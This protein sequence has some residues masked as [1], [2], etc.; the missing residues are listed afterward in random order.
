MSDEMDEIWELFADDGSQSLDAMEAA[1]DALT[2]DGTDD[3]VPHISALFRAVHTFK[4]NSRVVGLSVVEGRA[5]LAEDLIGLVRDSGVPLTPEIIDLLFLTGDTLRIMLDDVAATRADVDPEPSEDLLR[6]LKEMIAKCDPEAEPAPQADPPESEEQA[7]DTGAEA[8]MP[9][10]DAAETPVATAPAIGGM[11]MSALFDEM[12]D[13]DEGGAASGGD[14]EEDD[15]WQ[16]DEDL[17]P[18]ALAAKKAAAEADMEEAESERP[19][20]HGAAA[21]TPVESSVKIDDGPPLETLA[22]DPTYRKI[23]AEMTEDMVEKLNAILRS[24]DA[25]EDRRKDAEKQ[26][27]GLLHAA[28]QM[29]FADWVAVLEDFA[30]DCPALQDEAQLAAGLTEFLG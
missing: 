20:M 29:G 12:S 21:E 6:Q 2:D 9:A 1:L 18:D 5:H 8:E 10:A 22:D 26:A 3:Q 14:D 13:D 15:F 23:Y 27:D 16:F 19:V 17:D 4:G 30:F 7:A 24:D 11:D 28:Q 25:F